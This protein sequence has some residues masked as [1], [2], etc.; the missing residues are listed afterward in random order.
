MGMLANRLQRM[1]RHWRKW[2]RRSEVTCFRLYEKDIPEHP[3]IIDWY[4]GRALVWA[5][6]RTRDETDAQRARWL[7]QV[8]W[9][10]REGLDLP[11]PRSEGE[12]DRLYFKE[13]RRQRN[14]DQ[15]R[16]VAEDRREFVVEEQGLK[17]W[18][19]LSDYHDTGLF[20][21]HRN[22]RARVRA[23]AAY[24][25]VLNL[26]C[27]TGSFSVYAA[28]GGAWETVSVDLSNTYLGWAER[29]F[30]LNEVDRRRHHLV[31]ADVLD[32]LP[33]AGLKGERFDV[34]V[35]DPPTFS[36]SKRMR[37]VLDVGVQHP[38]LINGCLQLLAPGGTLYFSTNYRGFRLR[39]DE[40]AP[41]LPE[42]ISAETVPE[43][44]RNKKIHRC[45]RIRI[46][47]GG[48]EGSRA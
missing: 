47:E 4:D 39:E 12:E 9:E 37:D 1:L 36:N 26:F 17:F 2:A 19:N 27:Y 3:L 23:E 7:E 21:D 45:W 34:I 35:C 16:R 43:D 38:L 30:A 33:V 32:W 28:A 18:V 29:N 14:L 13:R 11:P 6:H 31:R 8:E 46:P 25:R 41:C 48:A 24:K 10:V 22:T 15:Y 20:L 42:E 5:M 40:L 44:Y